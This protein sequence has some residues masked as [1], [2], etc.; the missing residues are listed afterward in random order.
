MTTAGKGAGLDLAQMLASRRGRHLRR[1]AR[2]LQVGALLRMTRD[3]CVLESPIG[4]PDNARETGESPRPLAISSEPAALHGQN[5]KRI[6]RL[7]LYDALACEA[8]G[9]LATGSRLAIGGPA[10]HDQITD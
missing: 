8:M 5:L 6:F 2:V 7:V 9:T 1:A 4:S 10:R 3:E